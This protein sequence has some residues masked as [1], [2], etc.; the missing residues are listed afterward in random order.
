MFHRAP[1]SIG[2]SSYPSRVFKGTKMAGQMGNGRVTTK[3]LDVVR[4]DAENGLLLI[5]GAV[6]G[7]KGG[8]LVIRGIR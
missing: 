4:V 8:L 2:A 6:P 5:R 1:G 3:N 7:P